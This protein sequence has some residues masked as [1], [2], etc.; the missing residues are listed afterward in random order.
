MKLLE[1]VMRSF[2]L[3]ARLT[4]ALTMKRLLVLIFA[5][6]LGQSA[7]AQF[8]H[9]YVAWD[10][11]VKKHV[12]WLPDN[13]QSRVDYAAFKAERAELKKV[14]DS[15][16]VVPKAEFDGWSAPQRMAFLIN[17]YNAFTVELILTE[18]PN[19]KSIKQ[20]GPFFSTPW[21]I[22]F[23]KLLGEDRYLDWIE[24]EQLRP[25]YADP[26]VH[27]AVNCA[28]IGCP[29]LRNEAFTAPKLEAQLDDGMLRFM[30]DRT[31]NRMKDGRLEVSSIF[32][33]FGEDW[34]KGHK[35]YAQRDDL[36][37]KYAAQLTDD[38]GDQAKLRAK[39]VSA[40]RFD[41][42]WSLNAVGR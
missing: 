29:A 7:F 6:L 19:L 16:T 31:R 11:L 5:L 23:F 1:C 36:F 40:K 24:H 25:F 18:Y 34:E 2:T 37:A 38:A 35:G 39:T 14:L 12:K 17:A 26:R 9:N 28:A 42:D 41:Y 20:I 32:D 30:S 4:K 21:K 22:K 27:G 15:L 13:K 3:G 33:W 10:T 8:D